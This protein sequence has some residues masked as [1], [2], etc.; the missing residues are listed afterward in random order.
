MIS[1]YLL[2]QKDETLSAFFSKRL[3]K[4][5]IPMMFWSFF[6]VVW[7]KSIEQGKTPD[8]S[9]FKTLILEP[10]YYHLWFL[11]ALIGLYLF[12]PILR[13]IPLKSDAVI[14][15]YYILIWFIAVS[16]IPLAEKVIGVNS[17]IDLNSISGFIGYFVLGL[18]IGRQQVSKKL[19]YFSAITFTFTVI[20]TIYGTYWLTLK[21]NGI[22]AGYFYGYFSP[23]II[24]GAAAIFMVIKY[25]FVNTKLAPSSFPHK[26]IT[27]I[28][29]C[30][31]GVYLVHPVF[32][33]ILKT[34]ILGVKLSPFSG[35]AIVYVPLTAIVVFLLSFS[36]IFM[37]R[38]IPIVRLVAP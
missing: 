16:I 37:I 13:K 4:L 2:L 34:G 27:T 15:R 29:A 28:S 19:F 7:R 5:F 14:L 25:I 17:R 3:S 26:I 12:V 22:F 11:H 35:I 32:L 20:L 18:L 9:D 1:G 8:F 23:N 24:I 10:S 38:K 31:F 6:F 36:L 30:S 33:Y 21:N